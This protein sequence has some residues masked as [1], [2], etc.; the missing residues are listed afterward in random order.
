MGSDR[1]NGRA[2]KRGGTSEIYSVLAA[3]DFSVSTTSVMM[4]EIRS[5]R[6][7]AF[8]SR[9]DRDFIN[10]SRLAEL[11]GDAV[12]FC[13]MRVGRLLLV[14]AAAIFFLTRNIE[15]CDGRGGKLIDPLRAARRQRD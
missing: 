6:T 5:A 8:E 9:S 4:L 14:S 10:P 11:S 13:A 12:F 7:P 15:D 1:Q 3:A 2:L